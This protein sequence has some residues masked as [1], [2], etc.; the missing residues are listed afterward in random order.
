[1]LTKL[2]SYIAI[3]TLLMSCGSKS[4]TEIPTNSKRT[5]S[6]LQSCMDP[7]FDP[8]QD[9]PF[10]TFNSPAYPAVED[11]RNALEDKVDALSDD[12]LG[13]ATELLAD[14]MTLGKFSVISMIDVFVPAIS[15]QC[16]YDFYDASGCKTSTFISGGSIKI[17]DVKT[18]GPRLSFTSI[19]EAGNEEVKIVFANRNYD[20]LTMIRENLNGTVTASWDRSSDGIETFE[21]SDTKGEIVKYTENPDC[22]G[23]AHATQVTSYGDT[24]TTD[25][26]WT[27]TKKTKFQLKYKLCEPSEGGVIKC[28]EGEI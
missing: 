13:T 8:K 24:R 4:E 18:D 21:S 9:L 7:Y 15:M 19:N 2:V 3:V 11:K 26:E 12:D 10:I 6:K 25:F 14:T 20:G 23:K 17:K 28:T 5:K 16:N 1:M 22:S 27:S